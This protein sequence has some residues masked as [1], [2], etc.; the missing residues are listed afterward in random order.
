MGQDQANSKL[1]KKTLFIFLLFG[2]VGQIAWCIENSFLNLYVYRT[3]STNLLTVSAMVASSAVVAT[4]TTIIMGW[5]IDRSGRR[6]PFMV[7]GYI[8]WGVSVMLFSLFSVSNMQD[9]LGASAETAVI[10]ASVGMVIM[11]CVMTFFGSTAN[12]AAFNAYVTDNTNNKNRGRIEALLSCLAVVAYLLTFVP[13]EMGGVTTTKYYDASGNLLPSATGAVS[14]KPGNW[15]LFYCV[16]G[17]VVIIAG[18]AGFFILK[19]KGEYSVEKDAPAKKKLARFF[20]FD[21]EVSSKS[22][23]KFKDLFYGFRPSVIKRNKYLYLV[24]ATVMIS[25]I[26]NNCFSNFSAI[27]LQNTLKADDY[28]PVIGYL[29]PW[30]LSQGLAFVAGIIAGVMLDKTKRKKTVLII[31]GIVASCLGSLVM[32]FTSP[33]FIK[34]VPVATLTLY[35]IG[36]FIQAMGSSMVAVVCLGSVRNLTPPDKTGRFQGIRMVFVVMLPMVVGSIVS[37][38]VSSSDRYIVGVDEFGHDIYTCPPVMFLL[39]A[40]VVLL[41]IIPTIFLLKAKAEDL[42]TPA[43]GLTEETAESANEEIIA[44]AAADCDSDAPSGNSADEA[45]A[46]DVLSDEAQGN[47]EET[48]EPAGKA[49]EGTVEPVGDVSAE[50]EQSNRELCSEGSVENAESGEASDPTEDSQ[51]S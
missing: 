16:L 51:N 39:A 36:N 21:K 1:A 43:E 27:Y 50:S 10:L 29:L 5:V 17:A 48:G 15:T 46:P 22:D 30:G 3:I 13:F 34:D 49:S 9:G 32:Y 31:P 38:A 35:C 42:T 23:L 6:R 41:A 33:N 28:I 47:G 8:L 25:Y 45:N 20:S 24:L 44:E 26:A 18:I 37:G 7:Y 11:D 2:T 14:S 4:L 12:D 40:I 19:N